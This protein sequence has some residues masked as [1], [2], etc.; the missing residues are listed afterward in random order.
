MLAVKSPSETM[1]YSRGRDS[2]S[3]WRLRRQEM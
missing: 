3:L 1:F 2:C